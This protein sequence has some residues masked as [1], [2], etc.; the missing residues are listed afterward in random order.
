MVRC[1]AGDID[2]SPAGKCYHC[3]V[4]RH[5]S[6]SMLYSF[7]ENRSIHFHE[8]RCQMEIYIIVI[9]IANKT[10][11]ILFN[12]HQIYCFNLHIQHG[13]Y[14]K[15]LHPYKYLDI[16]HLHYYMMCMYLPND[17]HHHPLCSKLSTT[18][19][20]NHHVTSHSCL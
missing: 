19:V 1:I 16:L 6:S 10:S 9:C 20:C 8:D 18:Y 7:R 15:L 2:L 14:R 12:H 4:Y 5:S 3:L 11:L 17:N 13:T